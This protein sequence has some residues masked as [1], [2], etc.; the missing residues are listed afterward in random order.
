MEKADGEIASAFLC[1]RKLAEGKA[2]AEAIAL[3]DGGLL[4]CS[5]FYSVPFLKVPML[6]C[7]RMYVWGCVW[8]HKCV[9][10]CM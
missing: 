5:L 6:L 10:M 7:A 8:V 2:D 4:F 1:S 9:Y 3:E